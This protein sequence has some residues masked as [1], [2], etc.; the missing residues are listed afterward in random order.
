MNKFTYYV[1]KIYFWL[2]YRFVFF[3]W[4]QI[5]WFKS[6]LDRNVV[7]HIQLSLGRYLHLC[8]RVRTTT[9]H[10]IYI[11]TYWLLSLHVCLYIFLY[12]NLKNP[13][14][15]FLL[16]C[17][18][19][20]HY[21]HHQWY[22]RRSIQVVLYLSPTTYYAWR[23]KYGPIGL[24]FEAFLICSNFRNLYHNHQVGH[25]ADLKCSQSV[26]KIREGSQSLPSSNC[27]EQW[28]TIWSYTPVHFKFC[29]DSKFYETTIALWFSNNQN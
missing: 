9:I 13:P 11:K 4:S 24:H 29:A 1:R 10:E 3:M 25:R 15:V 16:S 7:F 27:C 20:I 17:F 28:D 23:K 5:D 26:R 18:L 6:F 22:S 21:Y 14:K 2:W 12:F 19:L 8:R